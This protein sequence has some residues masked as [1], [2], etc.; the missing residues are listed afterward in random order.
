M[1]IFLFQIL[2]K[3]ETNLPV[4]NKSAW[5]YLLCFNYIHLLIIKINNN[6]FKKWEMVKFIITSQIIKT[7]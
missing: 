4:L 1:Q 6:N 5:E 2:K 7:F 3:L